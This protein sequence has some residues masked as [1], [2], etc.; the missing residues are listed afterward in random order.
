MKPVLALSTCW[1][2]HRHQNG[3]EMV[4]EMAGL[5]FEWLELSHGIRITLVPGILRGVEEGIIKI[6]SCHNF[7]PLPNGVMH[8]APN[9]YLPTSGDHKE[10]DQWLR[11]SKRSVDFAAQ[12]GARNLV[13]HLG[14]VEFF[15][16]NPVNKIDAYL[17]AHPGVDPFEDT[18]YQK[19][20]TRALAKLRGKQTGFWKN[21]RAGID[22]LLPYATQK[23]VALG[24][25]KYSRVPGRAGPRNF[26]F[27]LDH[28]SYF[29]SS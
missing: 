25:E 19:I 10:R 1:C 21:M 9:L 18:D 15:W 3:Y 13:L 29:L 4:K 7:C 23:Q 20:L 28:G 17:D 24:F 6:A 11:H 8:A 5:G 12:V 26:D 14:S 27:G 16:F 22:E 2:S